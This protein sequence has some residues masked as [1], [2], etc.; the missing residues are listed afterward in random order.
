LTGWRRINVRDPKLTGPVPEKISNSYRTQAE[1]FVFMNRGIVLAAHSV[2]FD[3]K[4]NEMT[5]KMTNPAVH[6]L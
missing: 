1:L 4:S 3:N 6:G 5:I 2:S